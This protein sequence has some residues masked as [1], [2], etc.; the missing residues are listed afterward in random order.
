MNLPSRLVSAVLLL[1]APG[2]I[3]LA[4]KPALNIKMGLWELTTMSQ[5][6]GQMPGIDTSKMTPEQK[7]KFE[8]M[9]KSAVMGAHTNVTKS[10][11]SQEKFDKANF[12]MTDQD[13]ATCKQTVSTNTS[14]SLDAAVTCT[15]E[16][17]RV[18]QVH[19]EALS[20]TTFKGAVKFTMTENGRAMTVDG[21]MV[22]KWL[23]AD[24]GAV[25]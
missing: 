3:V 12:M 5:V 4:Q 2:A 23:A 8:A 10:C 24:C 17:P 21:T 18:G 14:A 25:K 20:S 1:V 7:E 9:M 16:H 15:G 19:V 11:I 13:A 6:G 22:G